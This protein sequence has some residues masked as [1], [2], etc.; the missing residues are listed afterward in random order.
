MPPRKG[1]TR[2]RTQTESPALSPKPSSPLPEPFEEQQVQQ[3]KPSSTRRCCSS[4]LQWIGIVT[5]SL[6][7]STVLFSLNTPVTEGDLAWTSRRL[8]SW[9]EVG[10]LLAWRAVELTVAW[11]LGYD[12]KD[13]ACLIGLV[14]MPTYSLLENFYNIRPTTIASVVT[15]T[16]FSA[17]F[18]F[19]YLRHRSTVRADTTSSAVAQAPIISDTPTTIYTTTAATLIYTV[20]LYLSFATWLAAYLITHYDGLPDIRVAHAGPRGFVSTFFRLILA[21]YAIRYFLFVSSARLQQR[22]EESTPATTTTPRK[23]DNDPGELLIASLYRRYWLGCR[24]NTRV[25]ISRTAVLA[26]LMLL[27]TTVQI[28]G[29]VSGAD[30]EGALGWAAVWTVATVI[31]GAVFWWIEVVDVV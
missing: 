10:G 11:A 23:T 29:T 9:W 26:T 27:N 3:Q 1:T 19:I 18:P 14:N 15:I 17:A 22:A 30:L 4:F 24:D 25:L 7:L 2:R 31:T 5:S 6:F 21:G 8:G 13:V 20:C 12:A 28:I 16:I